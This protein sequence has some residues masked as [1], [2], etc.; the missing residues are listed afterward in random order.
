[1]GVEPKMA[2]GIVVTPVA[3]NPNADDT[4]SIV[5]DCFVFFRV[6]MVPV[7]EPVC[8]KSIS[9]PPATT[10]PSKVALTWV[11]VRP[12]APGVA[13][14]SVNVADTVQSEKEGSAKDSVS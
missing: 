12:A 2:L 11:G 8:V 14:T 1:M 6:T 5:Q 13:N 10:T 3:E 7:D 9:L 4:L